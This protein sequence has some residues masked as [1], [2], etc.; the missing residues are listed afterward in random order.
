MAGVYSYNL[1]FL[2]NG[3]GEDSA[4][5]PDKLEG[6]HGLSFLVE[7]ALIYHCIKERNVIT[8]GRL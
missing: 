7:T 2:V 5:Y 4:A 8:R 6:G 1:R 3:W